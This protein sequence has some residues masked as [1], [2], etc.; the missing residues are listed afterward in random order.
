VRHDHVSLVGVSIGATVAA[1]AA[2]ADSKKQFA[3]VVL[4]Q[5][6]AGV[7][8]IL[9]HNAP[10]LGL[11]FS[12]EFCRDAGDWLF[13]PLE[14]ARYVARIAPRP[15]TILAAKE[16]AFMPADATEALYSRAK[17]PKQVIWLE[18][19]HVT[20]DEKTLITELSK[21][22]FTELAK[23]GAPVITKKVD[24]LGR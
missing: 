18:G 14:P 23:A 16:D 8:R 19:P 10:R 12:P 3:Q 20:P 1:A 11:P 6:G 4:V 13:K 24:A 9:A 15:L 17:D 5:G 7:G 21:R 2:A 22:V